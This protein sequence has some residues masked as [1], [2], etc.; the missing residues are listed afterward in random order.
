MLSNQFAFYLWL[1]LSVGVAFWVGRT[2]GKEMILGVGMAMAFLGASWFEIEFLGTPINVRIATAIVLLTAFCFHSGRKFFIT[3]TA[4]DVLITAILVWHIVV[5]VSK[6][7]E[8]FGTACQAYGEWMLPYATGRYAIVSRR[9]LSDLAP[10]FAT[11]GLL[12]ALLA[13]F[14]CFAASNVWSSVVSQIDDEVT[15]GDQIR[16]GYFHRA[17]GNVR[18]PIFLAVILMLLLPWQIAR[19]E[20]LKSEARSLVQGFLSL[21]TATIGIFATVSRGPLLFLAMSIGFV[22][23]IQ[24]RLARFVLIPAGLI[25]C[26]LLWNN[27]EAS[28][29]YFNQGIEKTNNKRIVQLDE[30]SEPIIQSGTRNRLTVLKLYAP[31][32]MKGGMT[33]YGTAASEGFP[34]ANIPGLPSDPKARNQVAIIDNSYLNVGLRLGLV[35]LSLFVGILL[36]AIAQAASFARRASTY[37]YPCEKLSCL[38]FSA[39]LFGVSLEM[40]SVYLDPDFSFLLLFTIGIVSAFTSV[41]TV[42]SIE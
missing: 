6:G 26:F 19:I 29:R 10:W 39:I 18:H 42:N 15:I 13:I 2:K 17:S 33:G 32:I 21:A 20:T 23:T 36:V 22:I 40:T 11:V 9:S 5:D 12:I 16:Y 24:S 37:L 3:V 14:E 25:A 4:L 30:S 34:P 31:I 38:T 35:G 41:S 28:L 8:F 27:F 1:T 7:A